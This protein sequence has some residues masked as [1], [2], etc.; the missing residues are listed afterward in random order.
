MNEQVVME[1]AAEPDASA[2]VHK[3]GSYV[4]LSQ[5]EIDFLEGLQTNVIKAPSGHAVVEDGQEFAATFLVR[6]GWLMRYKVL[7][8]G[9]RQILSFSLPGDFIGLHV[10]FRR[11][12]AYHVEAV[13]DVE[14]ALIEP[15]RTLDIYSRYPILASGLSW[16]TVREYNILGEHAVSL[17]RRTAVGRLAH[18]FLELSYRLRLLDQGSNIMPSIPL[19]QQLLADAL[20]LSTVHT[21]RAMRRL[22][23]DGLISYGRKSIELRNIDG[24]VEIADFEPGFLEAFAPKLPL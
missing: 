4:L 8:D 6:N 20:G 3:L 19:T 18:L 12:A 1:L 24:L 11:T 13:S 23:Q 5:E 9:R 21:N 22:A 10:N 15:M 2:L 16:S 17:G 7:R 14:L